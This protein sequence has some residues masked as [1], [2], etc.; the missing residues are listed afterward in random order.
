MNIPG[1]V[2]AYLYTNANQKSFCQIKEVDLKTENLSDFSV[3][4]F[5]FLPILTLIFF[6]L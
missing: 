1:F 6:F 5:H 3:S 2:L 4:S